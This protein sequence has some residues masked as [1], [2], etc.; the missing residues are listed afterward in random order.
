MVHKYRRKK[1]CPK[2]EA[3]GQI[4]GVLQDQAKDLP[5][6]RSAEGIPDLKER[7]IEA[8]RKIPS[9]KVRPRAPVNTDAP[10][11]MRIGK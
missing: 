9:S 10:P 2:K 5:G 11:A 7:A 3:Q 4:I 1:P 6:Q 8:G